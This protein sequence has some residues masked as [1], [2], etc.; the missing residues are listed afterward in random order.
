MQ[1]GINEIIKENQKLLEKQKEENIRITYLFKKV[2]NNDEGEE[3]LNFLEKYVKKPTDLNNANANYYR[4]GGV[5]L[6]NFINKVRNT[7]V[8]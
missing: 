1:K 3:V 2:F 5:D 6:V 8:R 7:D 4:D